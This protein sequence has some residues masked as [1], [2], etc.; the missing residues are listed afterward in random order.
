MSLCALSLS[1]AAVEVREGRISSAELVT[2]C[3]DR[4]AEVDAD[5]QAWAVLD[6]EHALAQARVLDETR[7]IGQALGPLHGVPVGVKDIFDT[8]NMPTEFGSPL[9]SGRTPRRDAAAV[10]RL[11]AAGAVIMGKTVTAEYAYFRRARSAA[12]P[13]ARP[14]GR[15]RSAGWSAS[16]PA[17]ASFRAPARCCC[18]ARST[19]SA[20]S[21]EPLRTPPC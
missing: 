2:A 1:E 14:F 10:A 15:R 12:R 6:R 5:I 3:L 20:C 13:M 11:R 8:A 9:W 16:S 7:A 21:R 17:M 4:V 19:T 18:R